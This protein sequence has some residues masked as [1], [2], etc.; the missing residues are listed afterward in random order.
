M[1]PAARISDLHTCPLVT[2][3]VPHVG[4]PI[5]KGEPTVVIGGMPAARIGDTVTCVGPTDTIIKGSP[6]VIIGGMPAA[7]IGDSTMHGGVITLGHMTTIIGDSGG[8]GG[9]G[10]GAA[11]GPG[12]GE[13]AKAKKTDPSKDEKTDPASKAID[14][15]SVIAAMVVASQTGTPLVAV[16]PEDET[17]EDLRSKF[18]LQVVD[19][20]TSE[21][22]PGVKVTITVPGQEEQT[23]TTDAQGRIEID[24]ID[25]GECDVTCELEENTNKQTFDAV[26][27][28]SQPL[29]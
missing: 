27:L 20:L 15:T 17:A 13:G 16:P 7:R 21:P 18:A 10:G 22:R 26:R 1:P 23:Y 29:L 6:T 14:P 3:T 24:D 28:D 25:P 12:G 5:L 11:G 2:G 4:G 9:G 8:G 19:D